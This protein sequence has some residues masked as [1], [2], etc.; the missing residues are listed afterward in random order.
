LRSCQLI[1]RRSGRSTT[2]RWV[3]RP[4]NLLLQ[5]WNIEACIRCWWVSFLYYT[6]PSEFFESSN[7]LRVL[8]AWKFSLASVFGLVFLRV[9]CIFF[10]DGARVFYLLD[11]RSWIL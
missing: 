2:Q 6:E 1:C 4:T 5:G 7:L 8:K 11:G 3:N 10:D 9:F